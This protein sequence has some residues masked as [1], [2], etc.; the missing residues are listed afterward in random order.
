MTDKPSRNED[1]F[2]AREEAEKLH[3]LHQE[4]LKSGDKAKA[5]EEKKLHFMKCP[6]CGYGLET[7]KWRGVDVDKC[8]RCGVIALDDGELEQLAGKE[9]PDGFVATFANLFKTK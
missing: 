3:K 6:K 9:N 8:F 5:E 7:I 2:F 4:K 1:E